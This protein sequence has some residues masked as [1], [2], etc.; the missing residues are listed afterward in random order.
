MHLYWKLPV[1]AQGTPASEY[2]KFKRD[3]VVNSPDEPVDDPNEW[4]FA[5][6]DRHGRIR[7]LNIQSAMFK[8]GGT[9]KTYCW[10][11]ESENCHAFFCFFLSCF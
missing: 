2:L 7:E 8:D 4:G 5:G 6:V 1:D 10:R 3:Q 9:S 11:F